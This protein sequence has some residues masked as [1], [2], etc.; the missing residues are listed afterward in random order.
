M[1]NNLI[2]DQYNTES[3]PNSNNSP[4]SL[5]SSNLANTAQENEQVRVLQRQI[6]VLH[7]EIRRLH[8]RHKELYSEI[9]RLKNRQ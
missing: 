1:K 3:T 7:Q 5:G 6:A 8:N 2:Q 9:E 4:L